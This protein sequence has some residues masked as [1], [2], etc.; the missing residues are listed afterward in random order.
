[1][2]TSYWQQHKELPSGS[3]LNYPWTLA[4]WREKGRPQAITNAPSPGMMHVYL[5]YL[6]ETLTVT[7]HEDNMQVKTRLVLRYA[8][9]RPDAYF[10]VFTSMD[11]CLLDR[12]QVKQ[13]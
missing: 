2:V 6:A 7:G 12:V 10:C 13:S 3:A 9:R 5:L 8:Q 1:M 11:H 4:V